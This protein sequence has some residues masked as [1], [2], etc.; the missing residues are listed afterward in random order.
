MVM[1]DL[2]VQGNNHFKKKFIRIYKYLKNFFEKYFC[3]ECT[4]E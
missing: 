1:D 4:N 2:F 3:H